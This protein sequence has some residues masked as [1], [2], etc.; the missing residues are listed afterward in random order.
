MQVQYFG[1]FS[2]LRMVID[3]EPIQGLLSFLAK[4]SLLS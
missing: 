1:V 2:K 3:Q 4:T